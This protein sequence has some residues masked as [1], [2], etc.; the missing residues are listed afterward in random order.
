LPFFRGVSD[1]IHGFTQRRRQFDLAWF[2]QGWARRQLMIICRIGH[3]LSHWSLPVQ[4]GYRVSLADS[5]DIAA[6]VGFKISHLDGSFIITFH[7]L[8]MTYR[9]HDVKVLNQKQN[10]LNSF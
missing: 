8:I 5:P 9:G 3:N 1:D 6:Q 7:D 4:Q 10:Q 2:A